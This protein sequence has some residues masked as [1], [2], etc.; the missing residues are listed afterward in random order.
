MIYWLRKTGSFRFVRAYPPGH[1]YSPLPDYENV[2]RGWTFF[3]RD[4][5]GCP[6]IDL[7][8][9]AQLELMETFSRYYDELPWTEAPNGAT[10]YHYE[11]DFFSYGDA[12]TMYSLFRH[13]KPRRVVEVGSGYSSAAMMDVNDLFLEKTIQF[14]FVE[15]HPKR[16]LGLLRQEEPIILRQPVQDTPLEEF[17]NLNENDV[18]FVDSSHVVKAGSDLQRI[19][20]SVL[21]ALKPGVFV[22][23]HD[24]FWPF[25]Y[26]KEWFLEGR[27]WNEAYLLRSFLQFNSAFEIVCFNSYLAA[28][29][30]DALQE[31]LPLFR[32]NPGGSLW[33]RKIDD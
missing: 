10:R 12:I 30:E 33:L 25:E 1:Y 31:R 28:C 2:L 9:G 22:H 32:K 29:H 24:I 13:Y 15:P 14:T 19:F 27:A 5:L 21:P 11:N 17:R 6:G 8:E 4:T 3:D 7:R 18:L 26:P 20:F 23:F 16:L